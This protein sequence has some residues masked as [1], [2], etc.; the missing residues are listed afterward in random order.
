MKVQ[1]V[2]AIAKIY[3]QASKAYSE[4]L[5]DYSGEDWHLMDD[6]YKKITCEAVDSLITE[7]LTPRSVHEYWFEFR[8]KHGWKYGPIADK[9]KKEHPYFMPYDE[10]PIE[11]RRRDSLLYEIVRIFK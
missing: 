9:E 11:K 2:E 6:E 3:H 7:D 8:S 1:K 10:L 5:G 4:T